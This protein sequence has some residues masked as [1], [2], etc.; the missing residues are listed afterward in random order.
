MP[1]PIISD[2]QFWQMTERSTGCWLWTGSKFSQGYG[3][4]HRHSQA[5][6]CHRLAYELAIGP[7]PE[8][9]FV[10]HRCDVR[11]CVNP[12]HLFLGSSQDNNDDMRSKGRS[13]YTG[14]KIPAFGDRNGSRRHPERLRR[15]DNHPAR[16]DPSITPRG[17]N[18]KTHV[19]TEEQVREI[20]RRY[21]PKKYGIHKLSA[22][23]GVTAS[24]IA[25]ILKR[26]SW[27]HVE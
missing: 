22:D 19:L 2:E 14:P 20:R 15:G 8:G 23:F 25:K 3:R 10:C 9:L 16:L 13:N 18:V 5:L 1:K 12:D 21:V 27:R 11:A 24:T 4:I 6:K 7:I 17:E 26:Q